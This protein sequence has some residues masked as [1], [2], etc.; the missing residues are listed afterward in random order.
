ML[1]FSRQAFKIKNGDCITKRIIRI[2]I[3]FGKRGTLLL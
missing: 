2:R 1:A 3:M